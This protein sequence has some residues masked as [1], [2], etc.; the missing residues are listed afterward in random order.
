MSDLQL[1]DIVPE[2]PLVDTEDSS[3]SATST[4]DKVNPHMSDGI[5]LGSS[6]INIHRLD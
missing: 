5:P 2:S 1:E 6:M 4:D 3:H